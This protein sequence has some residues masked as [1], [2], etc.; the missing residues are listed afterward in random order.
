[1]TVFIHVSNVS[2]SSDFK[3]TP[4]SYANTV[5]GTITSTGPKIDP[6]GTHSNLLL[7]SYLFFLFLCCFPSVSSSPHFVFSVNLHLLLL[8]YYFPIWECIKC[9]AKVQMRLTTFSILENPL[10]HLRKAI[11]LFWH[12][13]PLVNPGSFHLAF[14]STRKNHLIILSPLVI[15]LCVEIQKK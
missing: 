10:C 11:R 5:N 14:C 9:F 12:H 3:G 1:M 6:W 4:T 15:K 7:Y 13:V 8:H 2:S